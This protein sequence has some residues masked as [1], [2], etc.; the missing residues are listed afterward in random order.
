MLIILHGTLAHSQTVLILQSHCTEHCP[1][2][3][4]TLSGLKVVTGYW[5]GVYCPESRC[6]E[7]V[8]IDQGLRNPWDVFN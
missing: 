7:N 1:E 3:E 8:R 6:Y 4:M 2:D 5:R